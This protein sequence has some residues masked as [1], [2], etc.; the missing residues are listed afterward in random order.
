MPTTSTRAGGGALLFVLAGTMLVDS[1]EVALLGVAVPS[2][3][4]EMGVSAVAAQWALTAFPLGFAVALIPGRW[5]TWRLGRRR[6]YL[7]ALVVFALASIG[8]ALAPSVPAL[9]AAELV[10]GLC[11][12]LTAPVGIAVIGTMFAEGPQQRRAGLVYSLAGSAGATAGMLLS[13]LLTEISWRWTVLA[14]APVAAVLVAVGLG[15]LPD[16]AIT[17]PLPIRLPY[18]GSLVRSA[19]G[20]A[21]LNGSS[22]ALIVVVNL[23]LQHDRGWPPLS[24]ALVCLPAYV[25][26]VL[27]A[28]LAGRLIPRWG[29]ARPV[30]V[31][32]VLA[33][34]GYVLYTSDPGPATV[35]P[36]T[37]LLGVAY[38]CSFAALNVAATGQVPPQQRPAAGLVIQTVVQ[39]G[40]VAVVPLAVALADDGGRTAPVLVTVV[41]AIGLA[42]ALLGLLPV[43]ASRK[44]I[45]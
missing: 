39:L 4:R 30:V 7:G 28:V 21:T 34:A 40:A 20:A 5:L 23:Q 24:A 15:A 22:V 29:T 38:L 45:P 43:T 3:R 16:A 42:T 8:A 9:A 32:S 31:G 14:P 41:G 18:T 2:I 36:T 37:V 27:S 17:R 26:L 10:K 35:L 13:G 6:S 11:A 19:I 33:V 1:L 44:A 25:T 12:G